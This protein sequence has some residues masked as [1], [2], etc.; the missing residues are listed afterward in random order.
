MNLAPCISNLNNALSH[1]SVIS[2]CARVIAPRDSSQKYNVA[3]NEN[4]ARN[5]T[6]YVDDTGTVAIN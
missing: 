1:V 3:R 5:T 6:P 4:V 2:Q